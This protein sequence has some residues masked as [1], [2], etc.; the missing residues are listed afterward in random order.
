MSSQTQ[1]VVF[2][3]A[4]QKLFF[5]APE[6]R[7]SSP[8]VMVWENASGDDTV[9]ELALGA[10]AVELAPVTTFDAA[11]G[12]GQ[13]DPRVCNLALTTGIKR[14]RA[15]LVTSATQEQELVEVSAVATEWVI[16][17]QQL[18]NAYGV[19][20]TFVSTRITAAIDAAWL[21]D[22]DNISGE[23]EP[24]GRYRVRWTYTADGEVRVHDTYFD[25]VRYAGRHDVTPGDVNTEFH[26]WVL[27]LPA[28]Y[29]EEQGRPLIDEAYRQV[30][31]DLYGDLIGDQAIRNRE[32]LNAL[33]T[34]KAGLLVFP[35][36][37]NE[38][39]YASRYGQLI[40]SQRLPLSQDSGGGASARPSLP[41]FVR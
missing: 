25:V 23:L 28:E 7:P 32:L 40:R 37:A 5:D 30:K 24:D 1:D 41:I 12:Q 22:D 10:V 31:L 29:R 13:A 33:V 2:G 18:E 19:G 15:Y 26:G 27:S 14:G 11:S 16:A 39:K 20:D 34:A 36:A 6:G 21:A 17:R 3:V 9:A 35:G 38:A 8:T 4:G